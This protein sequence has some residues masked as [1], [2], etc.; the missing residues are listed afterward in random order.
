MKTLDVYAFGNALVDILVTISDEELQWLGF[1]RASF[2]LVEKSE[3]KRLLEKLHS[4]RPT[5]V[6]GGSVANSMIGLAQLGGVGAFSACVGD[7]RY[8]MHYAE[9]LSSLGLQVV[10]PIIVGGTTGT[11]AVLITPDAERT[12]RCCLGDAGQL[13]I[14]RI[15]EELIAKAK[16]IF[17]EGYVLANPERGARVLSRAAHL[18]EKYGTKIA[19]TFSDEWVVNA[20][21]PQLNDL[22]PHCDLIFANLA[23]AKAFTGASDGDGAFKALK[24][25]V[26]NVVVSRGA[27]GV[28]VFF[29]ERDYRV[30]AFACL[31]KDLTGAGDM[32]AGAF[33][34]GITNGIPVEQTARAACFMA[35][36]VITRV[37]ARLPGGAKD[38][39]R[40]GIAARV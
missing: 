10:N 30:P 3:Q 2:A 28:L 36:Q 39:W 32:L 9:E 25:I 22:V 4:H 12:M 26:P 34:Y 13:D 15:D 18:A 6:S 33:L 17:L 1:E 29:E 7:D 19:I 5:L 11:V 37:G 14:D 27:D 23:E 40:E 35:M 38:Y 8:G 21:R 20:C 31:P 24:H 16:W